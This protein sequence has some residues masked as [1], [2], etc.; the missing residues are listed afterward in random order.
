MRRFLRRV[1]DGGGQLALGQHHSVQSDGTSFLIAANPGAR[2]TFPAIGSPLITTVDFWVQVHSKAGFQRVFQ[3]GDGTAAAGIVAGLQYNPTL[4]AW[5][6]FMST[7]AVFTTLATGFAP[8]VDTWYFLS[9]EYTE[10]ALRLTSWDLTHQI[11]SIS[12]GLVVAGYNPVANPRL[13]LFATPDGSSLMNGRVD[14][15][16]FW[17]QASL[18]GSGPIWNNGQALEFGQVPAPFNSGG[19]LWADFNEPSAATSYLD[20]TGTGNLSVTGGGLTRQ[21]G[22]GF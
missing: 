3:V 19:S 14:A 12:T 15:F 13:G 18:P 16:G 22:A 20:A 21:T 9:A 4:D 7:G 11:E 17:S 8:V 5:Q 2:F 6:S 10:G 1:G